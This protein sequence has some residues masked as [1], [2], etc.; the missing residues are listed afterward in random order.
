MMVVMLHG[1]K[2]HVFV[3]RILHNED[4]HMARIL[5]DDDNI[6]FPGTTYVE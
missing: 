1:R 4:C 2:Q 6:Q 5:W 3:I